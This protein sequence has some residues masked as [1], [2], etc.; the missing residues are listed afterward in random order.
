[1]T[2]KPATPKPVLFSELDLDPKLL[3]T[4]NDLSF[5]QTTLIQSKVIPAAMQG[6]DIIANA[7]T[8]TGKTLAFA[9]PIMQKII[10]SPRVQQRD[11]LRALVVSPTRELAQQIGQTFQSMERRFGIRSTVVSGGMSYEPQRQNLRR[12]VDVLVATP[13]RLLD[14]IDRGWVKLNAIQFAILDE[15]DQMLDMGFVQDIRTI[16]EA[17]NPSSQKMMFSATMPKEI[18]NLAETFLQD[19]TQIAV[20]PVSSTNP[21]ITQRAYFSHYHDKKKI[22][23]ELLEG[24]EIERVLVFARTK[25][26]AD[27]TAEYLSEQKIRTEVIHGDKSQSQ[28][29]RSLENFKKGRV[30]ILVASD[31]AAR[32]LDIRGITHV[33][34]LDIP[35]DPE[36]YVHRIGRTARAEATGTAITLCAP[37]D[38][39][40]LKSIE[41]LIKKSIDVIQDHHLWREP[42]KNPAPRPRR[43][44]PRRPFRS[45]RAASGGGGGGYGGSRR[46]PS[47]YGKRPA[48]RQSKA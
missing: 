5:T 14:L 12:G 18:K 34:N 19:A 27:M 44:G 4:L 24:D 25:M 46:G 7:Q 48:T 41:G 3:Q 43:G 10:A 42:I 33:I 35:D 2:D 36:T 38:W 22:L 8:G 1:M 26:G 21:N 16:L 17:S 29:R 47:S 6:I 20:A 45:G 40:K 32:G 11:R 39:P 31:V 13:G 28:R 37:D 30:N 9:I 23:L 15:A